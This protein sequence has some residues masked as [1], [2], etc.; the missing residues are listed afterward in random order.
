M[1]RETDKLKRVSGEGGR[2]KI[3]KNRGKNGKDGGGSEVGQKRRGLKEEEEEQR[4][5]GREMETTGRGMK[6]DGIANCFLRHSM[7]SCVCPRYYYYYYHY[8]YVCVIYGTTDVRS[9]I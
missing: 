2:E 5:H 4:I 1:A 8:I 9:F 7:C 3:G 6:R